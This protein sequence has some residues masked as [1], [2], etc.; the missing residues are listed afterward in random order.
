MS[1]DPRLATLLQ[2]VRTESQFV[3]STRSVYDEFHAHAHN[4][5]THLCGWKV[6][7]DF[8]SVPVLPQDETRTYTALAHNVRLTM[9]AHRAKRTSHFRVLVERDGRELRHFFCIFDA[10]TYPTIYLFPEVVRDDTSDEKV[11]AE[12]G[13]VKDALH[14]AFDVITNE[15]GN[16][17]RC[18]V[19]VPSGVDDA[20]HQAFIRERDAA[21][22]ISTEEDVSAS[23]R[24]YSAMLAVAHVLCD[25]PQYDAIEQSVRELTYPRSGDALGMYE[26]LQ[27]LRG[28]AKRLTHTLWGTKFH[29]KNV[30]YKLEY[31]YT[32]PNLAALDEERRLLADVTD[33]STRKILALAH[34]ESLRIRAAPADAFVSQSSCGALRVVQWKGDV[35][36]NEPLLNAAVH[37][38]LPTGFS[39]L[40]A[41]CHTPSSA[42]SELCAHV[43]RMFGNTLRRAYVVVRALEPEASEVSV[44]KST[45][46]VHSTYKGALLNEAKPLGT[47]CTVLELDVLGNVGFTHEEVRMETDARIAGNVRL[48]PYHEAFVRVHRRI[49]IE[50]VAMTQ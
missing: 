34:R 50:L 21:L 32:E 27:R 14:S 46:R 40:R 6:E 5:R 9:T 31:P 15:H 43:R 28:F 37:D 24:A 10:R 30:V 39:E 3:I 23:F 17:V 44:S 48:F 8:R 45:T 38:H 49:D 18:I 2:W 1:T 25:A 47:T 20:T 13:E 29:P 11:A 12:C 42:R 22:G 19:L 7:S 26:V 35:V 41:V 4:S 36:E 33:D 16:D